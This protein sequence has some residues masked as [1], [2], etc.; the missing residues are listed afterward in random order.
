MVWVGSSLDK[1]APTVPQIDRRMYNAPSERRWSPIELHANPVEN[2]WM[3]LEMLSRSESCCG[4]R[5]ARKW[6]SHSRYERIL[7]RYT[8]D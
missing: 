3:I 4:A 2:S 1:E 7:T 8:V 6:T 5:R